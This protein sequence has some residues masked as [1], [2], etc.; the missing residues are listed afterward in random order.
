[1]NVIAEVVNYGWAAND[2]GRAVRC[3]WT[4]PLNRPDNATIGLEGYR[5]GNGAKPI[6]PP[7][8]PGICSV[9]PWCPHLE[10]RARWRSMSLDASGPHRIIAGAKAIGAL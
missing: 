4:E 8:Q 9:V 2:G 6:S 3:P 7:A 10:H 1:M 5:I